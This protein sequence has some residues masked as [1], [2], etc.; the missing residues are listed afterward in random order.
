MFTYKAEQKKQKREAEEQLAVSRGGRA[1]RRP[2]YLKDYA[3]SAINSPHSQSSTS[4]LNKR[5]PIPPS[6][7]TVKRQQQLQQIAESNAI[8]TSSSDPSSSS[9]KQ[10][11]AANLKPTP[12]SSTLSRS[13]C[14]SS[15]NTALDQPP[16]AKK[17]KKNKKALN[18]CDLCSNSFHGDCVGIDE[19]AAQEMDSFICQDCKMVQKSSS[20]ELYCL[21]RTTYDKG[22]FYVGCD[23]CHDWLHGTCVGVTESE[24]DKMDTYICPN[25]E[26]QG[27]STDNTLSETVIKQNHWPRLRAVIN[28]L[29]QHKLARPFLKPV[30]LSE[31]PNYKK[32]VKEPMDLSKVKR[33]LESKSYDTVGDFLKDIQKIFD[34]CR[35]AIATDS[36]FYQCAEVLETHFMQEV[37]ALKEL[38]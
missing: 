29:Q 6:S 4:S 24:A 10:A 16:K 19:N 20:E 3:L 25:C 9:N 14:Q 28:S 15:W 36:S 34:N 12:P 22:Q 26:K 30:K 23:Q 11:A 35:I 5:S 8:P 33:R 7:A 27:A 1:I 31:F 38:L 21:C 18:I 2:N 13:L 17:R 32:F 37:K